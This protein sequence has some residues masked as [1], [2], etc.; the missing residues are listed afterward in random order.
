[1]EI[2]IITFHNVNN[3]GAVL[4]CYA[5]S[6]ILKNKG[7]KVE[8]I[9]LP[10][11]SKSKKIRA[12]V[13]GKLSS[14]AFKSFRIN[15]LP[16]T[17]ESDNLKDLYIFGS[18]QIWNL[19]ITKSNFK[20]YFGSWI[21][22]EVPKIA[23]AASFGNSKWNNQ[24]NKE[25]VKKLLN[26][27][28]SIGIRESSGV[29]I[30]EKEFSIKCDKVLDPT[31]LLNNYDF[32]LKKINLSKLMVCYIFGKDELKINE[33]KKI[34][35]KKNLK[36][37]LLS[38]VRLRKDIKSIPFPT[39]SKWLSYLNTSELILTDSFHC[40]VFAILF[41]KNF[42]AIPAIPDRVDRMVS[43]LSDLGL[44]SRFF[45]NIQEVFNSEVLEEDIDYKL[46]DEK[47]EKL[48]VESFNFLEK[49]L[50]TIEL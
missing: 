19:D 37:V 49:S 7:Y 29:K 1:M 46:V 36:P 18:D 11:H 35:N 38:D 6:E 34:A 10:L 42:I 32:L 40:M 4:Q 43:L 47:L 30:C 26:S 48:K 5:L 3:Y 41:K 25:D 22:K 50:K 15:F 24:D 8:L 44:K 17:V 31:F 13:S 9:N 21:K 23:Y 14:A 33:L 27:F 45:K 20:L 12:I 2:G 28:S 16:N 39:V